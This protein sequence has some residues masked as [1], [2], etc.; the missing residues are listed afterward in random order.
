M[1]RHYGRGIGKLRVVD[2]SPLNKPKGTTLISAIHSDGVFAQTS[3][4]GGTTKERFLQYVRET[5]V[6][7]LKPGKIVVIDNL[8]AHHTPELLC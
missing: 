1:V 6:P 5:L 4:L 7:A 3:Y 8:T 2:R